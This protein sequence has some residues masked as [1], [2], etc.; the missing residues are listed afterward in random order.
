MDR[1][2][3]AAVLE[4]MRLDL[5]LT[6]TQ[7]GLLQ[8]VFLLSI[9]LFSLPMAFLIDRWSRRKAIAVMAICGARLPT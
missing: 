3:F 8:T 6:D 9:T 4:P 2:V 7:I 5:G 1:Q